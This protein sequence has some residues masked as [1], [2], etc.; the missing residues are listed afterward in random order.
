MQYLPT[1]LLPLAIPKQ[2]CSVCV[3]LNL[4]IIG[5]TP[6]PLQTFYIICICFKCYPN[7]KCFCFIRVSIF[8]AEH[9]LGLYYKSFCFVACTIHLLKWNISSQGFSDVRFN[10]L[11]YLKKKYYLKRYARKPVECKHSDRLLHE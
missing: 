9:Y 5:T 2:N 4:L 1:I 10:Q 8:L 7:M 6:I 11:L 3:F